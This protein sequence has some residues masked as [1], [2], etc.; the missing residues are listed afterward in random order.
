MDRKEFD[1]YVDAILYER[2][3][4]DGREIQKYH[5]AV[6]ALWKEIS[7]KTQTVIQV[8]TKDEPDI[9]HSHIC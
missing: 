4:L 2:I 1:K 7:K 5:E 9:G 8:N 6:D 3:D